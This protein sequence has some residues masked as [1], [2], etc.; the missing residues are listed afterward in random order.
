M[1]ASRDQADQTLRVQLPDETG[2]VPVSMAHAETRW[3]GVPPPILLLSVGCFSLV[4]ALVLFVNGSWPG[5]LVLL[6]VS[7]LFLA[8]FL[9]IARRRPDSSFTR[10]SAGAAGGARSWASTRFELVRAHSSAIAESQR[11]RGRRSVIESE[12]RM[13]VLRLGEAMRSGDEEAAQAARE[14]LEELERAEK[15]LH[16]RVEARRAEAD[17]RIRKVR[18]SVDETMVVEPEPSPDEDSRRPAA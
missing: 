12:R 2:P 6:G 3:F 14:R 7:G 11:V 16:G 1:P 18:L 4:V 5:G 9:E 8:G 10:A 13:A 15:A 17:D